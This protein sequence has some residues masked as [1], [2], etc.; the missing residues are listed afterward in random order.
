[1][2]FLLQVPQTE[3]KEPYI[4]T[5][6]HTYIRCFHSSQMNDNCSFSKSKIPEVLTGTGTTAQSQP[7]SRTLT[8]TFLQFYFFFHR[9]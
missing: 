1:M 6:I 5:Y 2:R 7:L 9:F 4:H 8:E 3:S